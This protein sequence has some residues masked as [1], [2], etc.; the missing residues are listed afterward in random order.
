VE[1]RRAGVLGVRIYDMMGR[2]VRSLNDL[3]V[4]EPGSYGVDLD[5]SDLVQGRYT[6]QVIEGGD[7]ASTQLLL[8]R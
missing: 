6:I 5:L 2:L 1:V 8:V 3:P 4:S 7:R